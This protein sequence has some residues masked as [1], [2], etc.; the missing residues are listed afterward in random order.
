MRWREDQIL[1]SEWRQSRHQSNPLLLL[2]LFAIKR[3]PIHVF[4]E[5]HWHL[6]IG[7]SKVSNSESIIDQIGDNY[8]HCLRTYAYI[9]DQN[10]RVVSL[11]LT[12]NLEVKS[13]LKFK[14]S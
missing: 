8:R 11:H 5:F 10:Q 2:L 6:S 14:S 4:I 13:N 1:E 9:Y 7:L 3:M 12:S